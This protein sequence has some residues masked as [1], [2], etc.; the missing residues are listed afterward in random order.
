MR[1]DPVGADFTLAQLLP[2]LATTSN[3]ERV[4]LLSVPLV[5]D[6]VATP[7]ARRL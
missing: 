3:Q 5:H 4:P 7:L 2:T 1:L 6:V